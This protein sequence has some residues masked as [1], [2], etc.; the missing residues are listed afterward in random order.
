M[1]NV[2]L[3]LKFFSEESE[4]DSVAMKMEAVVWVL[5]LKAF[6]PERYV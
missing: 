4:V 5:L 6:S 3:F 1:P 2:D